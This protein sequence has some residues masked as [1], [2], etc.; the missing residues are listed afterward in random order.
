MVRLT[1]IFRQAAE[2]AIVCNAHRST[3]GAPDLRD[4]KHDFSSSA[5]RS[6][7]GRRRPSWSW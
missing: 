4:N 6:R 1:E 7:P 3:G 2:S 5:A